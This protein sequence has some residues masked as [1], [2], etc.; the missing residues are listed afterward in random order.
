MTQNSSSTLI[1]NAYDKANDI[2]SDVEPLLKF[3]AGNHV[4]TPQ[5]AV[6]GAPY[7]DGEENGMFD[8]EVITIISLARSLL[9]LMSVIC[10]IDRGYP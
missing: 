7:Y 2:E 4:V 1:K 6:P 3:E 10:M 8:E 5:V 9:H